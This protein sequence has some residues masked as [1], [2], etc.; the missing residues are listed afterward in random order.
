[1]FYVTDEPEG[2]FLYT[3]NVLHC[4]FL[5]CSVFNTLQEHALKVLFLVVKKKIYIY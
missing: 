1:M 2:K 5:F 3:E 4:L